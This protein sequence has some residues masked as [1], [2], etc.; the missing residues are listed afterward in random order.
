MMYIVA[1]PTR[2]IG[3]NHVFLR[4]LRR[5][6]GERGTWQDSAS[7]SLR[8][9][10][11]EATAWAKKKSKELSAGKGQW[12]ALRGLKFGSVSFWLHPLGL[13]LWFQIRLFDLHIFPAIWLVSLEIW[14][15][16]CQH[17]WSTLYGTDGHMAVSTGQM[18][19][20]IRSH[21]H[22]LLKTII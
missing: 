19:F 13:W 22:H 8:C 9:F 16:K 21:I 15:G 4:Q 18:F 14:N 12:F 2:K 3:R 17:C 1:S 11:T 6:R 20:E 7:A 5:A 10:S